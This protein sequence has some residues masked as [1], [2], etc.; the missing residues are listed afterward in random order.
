MLNTV[1]AVRISILTTGEIAIL[2]RSLGGNWAQSDS[3]VGA[4]QAGTE[5]WNGFIANVARLPTSPHHH[6]NRLA[7]PRFF[8]SSFVTAGSDGGSEPR[9]DG[10]NRRTIM[11][12][13]S[14]PA[15]A[16]RVTPAAFLPARSLAGCRAVLLH[17]E[18]KAK[19]MGGAE[20]QVLRRPVFR[21]AARFRER[22]GGIGGG[23]GRAAAAAVRPQP[24]RRAR[25]VR[26]RSLH[27]PTGE[28]LAPLMAYPPPSTNCTSPSSLWRQAAWISLHVTV[29]L[30][31]VFGRQMWAGA[32]PMRRTVRQCSYPSE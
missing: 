22:W 1:E 14:A 20:G 27:Q 3:A 28:P 11:A 7:P 15:S 5:S 26:V 16:C 17:E 10:G 24:R 25:R 12:S 30:V 23:G 6:W 9:G 19:E 18:G 32:R 2:T 13:T 8:S 31:V 4:Q 21:R 29:Q